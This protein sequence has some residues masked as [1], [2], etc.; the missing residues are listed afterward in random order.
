M[1]DHKTD[2]PT[3]PQVEEGSTN[4]TYYQTISTIIAALR[5]FDERRRRLWSDH[6]YYPESEEDAKDWE[7]DHTVGKYWGHLLSSDEINTLCEELNCGDWR[8]ERDV[9][10]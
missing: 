10:R 7:M 8:L 2:E 1:T 5:L 6:A 3:A 4:D 9:V